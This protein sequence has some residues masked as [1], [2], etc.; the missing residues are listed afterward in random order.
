[1]YV[2]VEPVNVF[3]YQ[4]LAYYHIIYM[5][6]KVAEEFIVQRFYVQGSEVEKIGL[7]D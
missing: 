7:Q 4:F 6:R 3:F 5:E 1:L 2:T